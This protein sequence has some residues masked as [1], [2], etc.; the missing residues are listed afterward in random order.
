MDI[1]L[2]ILLLIVFSA[3]KVKPAGE[4]R[5]DYLEKQNTTAIKGLFVILVIFSHFISYT[6]TGT[7]DNIYMQFRAHL[8]QAVVAMFLFYSGF[9][10]GE[11]IRTKG[12]EYVRN[13]PRRRFFPVWLQYAFAVVLFLIVQACFGNFYGIKRILQALIAWKGVGNSDWY[14][15]GI[16]WLYILTFLSFQVMRIN[17]HCTYVGAVLL[18]ASTLGFA[19]VLRNVGRDPWWY[20]TLLVYPLG[21][22]WSLL[23][24]RID[25]IAMHSGSTYG[26]LLAL[27]IC[28]YLASY[29]YRSRFG[30]T[31][32]YIWIIMF[33]VMIV[34]MT[35]KISLDSPILCWF[36]EHTF[37]IYI[38]QRIP[39]IILSRLGIIDRRTYI[40]FA[41]VIA[42]TCVIATLFDRCM[43]LILKRT[44][45]IAN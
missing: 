12:K 31:S 22:W 43:N 45:R 10:I 32:Y 2:L 8:N 5:R 19:L 44:K 9:G 21:V 18:T 13:F 25:R 37:S 3:L 30:L 7:Y 24:P 39:M 16:L 11:S 4:F 20:N 33:T 41:M 1:Y 36:G 42:L 15:F 27:T 35:M 38:L 40:A 29:V 6:K 28:A 14:I 17:E 23:K 34:F 26:V